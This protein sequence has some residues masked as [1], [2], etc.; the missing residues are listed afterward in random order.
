MLTLFVGDND[1]SIALAAKSHDSSAYLIDFHNYNIL[2]KGTAYTSL[3]DLPNV[4][5]FIEV[6]K[7]ADTV[8]FFPPSNNQWSDQKK[9]QSDL[10]KWTEYYLAV[11]SCYKNK[12]VV[13]FPADQPYQAPPSMELHARQP[14]ERN[15]WV[16]GG[17]ISYG[18]GIQPAQ[19]YSTI[20][21]N[22]LN[23]PVNNLS[24][25]SASVVWCVNQLLQS[26]ICSSD[27]VILDVSPCERFPYYQSTNKT[28]HVG[29]G[30]YS[31]LPNTIKHSITLDF[32]LDPAII[33]LNYNCI[34]QLV[35]FCR[36]MDSTLILLG[37]A[38]TIE[39]SMLLKDL[40][41]YLHLQD[42]KLPNES[43][44]DLGIDNSHPGPKAHQW[45]ADQIFKFINDCI[46]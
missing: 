46:I 40:P 32:L 41:E 31:D 22:I 28:I 12:T 7:Q 10:K 17:S 9:G 6:L 18:Y 39:L 11:F 20:L 45:Y 36:K 38:S 34:L 25:V 24:A 16:G 3:S 30:N 8:I 13:N 27:I 19:N 5:S 26:D 35:N 4:S 21:G 29:A 33:M 23:L 43:F 15:I 14:S 2:H 44:I 42:F 37:L 1:L